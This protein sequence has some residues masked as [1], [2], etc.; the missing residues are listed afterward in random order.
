MLDPL[1]LLL[2]RFNLIVTYYE[3]GPYN[4]TIIQDKYGNFL[5]SGREETIF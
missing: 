1:R 2:T 5:L 3:V 4:I